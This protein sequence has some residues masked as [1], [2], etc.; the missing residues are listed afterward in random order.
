LDPFCGVGTILQEALLSK[1]KVVGLDIN[2]WCVNAAKRNLDWIA[3]EYS[4]ED[5]DYTVVQGDV[6][7][8][9]PK[10]HGNIDCIATEPDLGPALRELPTEEYAQ[11][12]ITHLMP[13][14]KA[15]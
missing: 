10:I 15:S 9:A 4:L 14:S 12:I 8:M 1:A 3:R 5:A 7:E 13:L 11:E 2:G 6:R